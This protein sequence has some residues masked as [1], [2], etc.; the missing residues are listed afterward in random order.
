M[1]QH[2]TLHKS[3]RQMAIGSKSGF[4]TFYLGTVQYIYSSSMLLYRSHEDACRFIVDFYQYLYLHLPEY[5]QSQ[6]V[7]K[8]I[9]R[10]LVE[11]FRQLSIGKKLPQISPGDSTDAKVSPLSKS[12]RDRIWRMLDV[13]IHFPKE[14]KERSKKKI[15]LLASLL[16]LVLLLLS[17]YMP[18]VLNQ[19]LSPLNASNEQLQEQQDSDDT[20]RQTSE[21]EDAEKQD[22]LE[23]IRSEIEDLLSSPS[24][25]ESNAQT[26]DSSF[27][28]EQKTSENAKEQ[29]QT[30]AVPQTPKIPEVPQTPDTASPSYSDSQTNAHDLEH[31]ELELRYGD[32]LLFSDSD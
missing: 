18:P 6:D 23:D 32:S 12:E 2:I 10:L 5:K 24:G 16:L 11:R 13:N 22:E 21:N 29:P 7:E 27:S 4:R 26:G 1:A 17:R 14:P 15:L 19:L 20:Q 28:Q 3:L 9:S 8:W 30:P 31:M 25:Q